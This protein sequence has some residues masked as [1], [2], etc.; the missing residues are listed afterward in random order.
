MEQG[1]EQG[2]DQER[3]RGIKGRVWSVTKAG[4]VA[5]AVPG[6]YVRASAGTGMLKS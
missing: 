1:Q 4:V 3:D 2:Q 6:L 5:G